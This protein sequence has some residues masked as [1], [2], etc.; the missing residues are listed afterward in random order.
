MN[1]AT[2][3]AVSIA[4]ILDLLDRVAPSVP[5]LALGQTVF[6]DEPMK[7]AL[8]VAAEGRRSFVAGVHDTDYFA[9]LPGLKN[10]T[11]GYAIVPHNDTNTRD[12]WSAAAE[13]S[14][15]F[16]SE[17]VVRKETLVSSGLKL[18]KVSHGRPNLLDS[19][20]EAWGWRTVVSLAENP[21]VTAE[22]D[23]QTVRPHIEKALRWAI[24]ETLSCVS[25]PD[26]VLARE[27]AELL[28]REFDAQSEHAQTLSEFYRALIPFLYRFVSG[29]EAEAEVTATSELLKFNVQTCNLPRF[30]L[31]NVFVDP[32]TAAA[33][34][35][36][37]DEAVTGSEIYTLDRFGSG[38]IPF[39][40]VVPGRGRGT[41]RVAPRALVVMTPTPI[42]ISLKKPVKSVKDL[43]EAIE[44]KLG[45]DCVL[46]GK[47]VSLI[48]MLSREFVFVFH[49]GASSYVT[50]TRRFHDLLKQRG[51]GLRWYPIL[52][53]RT[54]AWTALEECRSWIRLPEPLRGPFGAE[55]ICTPSFAARWKEVV[56]DQARLLQ[57][58]GE[59]KSPLDLIK[60][61][62][63]HS[64]GSWK[65][66]SDEYVG[67]HERLEGL[68]KQIEGL[69]QQRRS[70]Y[71][72]LKRSKQERVAA[73]IAKG[74]HFR[75]HIFE[76]EPDPV[77]EQERG[78][79]AEAVESATRRISDVKHEIRSL[80]RRQ[81]EAARDEE[82]LRIHDRRRAIETEAELKRLR[83]IRDAVITSKGLKRS[84][85]RPSAW[86]FP[87]LCPDGGW[88]AE[89]ARA[90]ECY[91][92]PLES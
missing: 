82:V 11:G 38:A 67:L 91:L 49:E 23:W 4:E 14:S 83:L 8:A 50:T 13:F 68:E 25:E 60:F 76:K 63:A 79:L 3:K 53:L 64:Q 34:R 1:T 26:R 69:R 32:E 20:T 52:R 70:L 77:R 86:W 89:T 19:A 43:A 85:R 71:A 54:S 29:K 74:E 61:L 7:A 30:D 12:L 88:F 17:T 37:Y 59:L 41:L 73:E 44:A 42:F 57:R 78:L 6:W 9:K 28:F 36:S 31:V 72:E 45:P 65:C 55:E 46:A 24:E 75:A 33:A 87:V 18:A 27:R 80:M 92:E 15:L 81:S 51:A 35:E 84:D 22:V 10:P 2:D 5:L 21:A 58:L 56:E 66:L 48:G 47:A 39:D 90:A 62:D 40:L 16:G